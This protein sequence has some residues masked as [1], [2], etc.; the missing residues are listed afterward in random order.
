MERHIQ[1]V[2]PGAK[3]LACQ[4]LSH[5]G[6]VMHE[7][8]QQLVSDILSYSADECTR[9]QGIPVTCPQRSA[10]SHWPQMGCI[11]ESLEGMSRQGAAV[12]LRR[13]LQ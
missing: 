10:S 11:D 2:V 12:S 6:E 9:V 3:S 5:L 8:V 4:L 7:A 1:D 13:V